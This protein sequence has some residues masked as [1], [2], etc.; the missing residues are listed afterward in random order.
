MPSVVTDTTGGA[1]P[2]WCQSGKINESGG[3]TEWPKVAVLKTAVSAMAPGVRI[4]RPPPDRFRWRPLLFELGPAGPYVALESTISTLGLHALGLSVL[5]TCLSGR[6][7]LPAKELIV[8]RDSGVRIPSSPRNKPRDREDPG[9]FRSP[10]SS[11]GQ[12]TWAFDS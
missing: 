7:G 12:L 11:L 8:L 6:K 5:E 4:P 9:V 2:E 1:L 3:L 10:R